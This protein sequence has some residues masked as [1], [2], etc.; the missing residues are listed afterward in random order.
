MRFN[1][2]E[3]IICVSPT[4]PLKLFSIS[5]HLGS[6]VSWEGAERQLTHLD[7]LCPRTL[8]TQIQNP[9]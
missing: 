5:P 3:M 2:V 4:V 6:P 9:C 1:E 8:L 7:C